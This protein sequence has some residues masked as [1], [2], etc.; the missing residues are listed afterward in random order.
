MASYP[1][2]NGDPS[3]QA[4]F[5]RHRLVGAVVL[6]RVGS[7]NV[8]LRLFREQFA[9]FQHG[10]LVQPVVDFPQVIGGHGVE[11]HGES[12]SV[13][14]AGVRLGLREREERPW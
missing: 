5:H 3:L 13:V 1:Q 6:Q 9:G 2:G 4:E 10:M 12:P 8:T 11:V 7:S 14:R